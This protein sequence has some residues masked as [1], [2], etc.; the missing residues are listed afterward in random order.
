MVKYTYFKNYYKVMNNSEQKI[1]KDTAEVNKSIDTLC[2]DIDQIKSNIAR[3]CA[4]DHPGWNEMKFRHTG[5]YYRNQ[6]HYQA[7]HEKEE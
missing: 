4:A 1:L 2:Q 3:Y 5:N 7:K 6:R